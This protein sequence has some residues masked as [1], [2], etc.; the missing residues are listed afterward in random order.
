[1]EKSSK[2]FAILIAGAILVAVLVG[3]GFFYQRQK[4]KEP[5]GLPTP[6][7]TP[8]PTARP[9]PEPTSLPTEPA[10]SNKMTLRIYFGNTKLGSNQ[11]CTKVYPVNRRI[12]KTPVVAKAALTEL[13]AGPTATEKAEG[14]SSFF[15]SATKG[16][17][18]SVKVEEGTAYVNLTDIRQIIPNAST[19][20]GS[21]QFLAEMGSTLK[22][23]PTVKKVIFAINGQPQ[24][25]YDWIQIGCSAENDNCDATPF[26]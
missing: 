18:K 10:G 2:N 21:A 26:K 11:D 5:A 17:L 22:Q 12:T 24:A 8:S 16:I 13:F 19:S 9:T 14:Y 7:V 15:S 3:G 25:F 6:T 23:F 1:M 20:C 4:A